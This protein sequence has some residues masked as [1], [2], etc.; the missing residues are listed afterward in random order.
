MFIPGSFGFPYPCPVPCFALLFRLFLRLPTDSSMRR[1]FRI[2]PGFCT[3]PDLLLPSFLHKETCG[4]L[5][6]PDY[7]FDCM[8]CSQTP[9][10]SPTLAITHSG[11]TPS[12]H[13]TPSTFPFGFPKVYPDDHNYTH[14][15]AQSHSL[16]P[17]SIRLRTP[18]AGFAL[19]FLYRPVGY[20]L[21]GWDSHCIIVSL[22][23]ATASPARKR[24]TT[25]HS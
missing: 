23:D 17:R 19:G 14:F 8:P 22:L 9:V 25:I 10:V 7:P 4:S 1:G 15:G 5:K 16:Q 12:G 11:L 13:S 21:T 6:F 3:K 24:F 2:A 20:T 18:V